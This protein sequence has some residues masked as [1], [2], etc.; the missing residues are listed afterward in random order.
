[1][2]PATTSARLHAAAVDARRRTS[3]DH[4]RGYE[5]ISSQQ[6]MGTSHWDQVIRPPPI[7]PGAKGPGPP[8]VR[9]AALEEAAAK[10]EEERRR[11]GENAMTA[12]PYA[13]MNGVRAEAGETG[14]KTPNAAVGTMADALTPGTALL[15]G[16]MNVAQSKAGS[17][18]GGAG[19]AALSGPNA[20]PVGGALNKVVLKPGPAGDKRRRSESRGAGGPR[21]G[22]KDSRNRRTRKGT[23]YN[24]LGAGC[25]V[26]FSFWAIQSCRSR[27][28]QSLLNV[29]RKILS[30]HQVVIVDRDLVSAKKRNPARAL[31][32]FRWA[33]AR[34]LT[35]L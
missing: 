15:R 28:R 4:L 33:R 26:V 24:L 29:L 21:R 2:A 22:R 20:Q 5:T 13:A 8:R 35:G 17:G 32:T 14:G 23:V 10:S 3:G 19:A 30:A 9:S 27:R 12:N 7:V 1:M 6:Q 34:R 25:C 31:T 11:I 18:V 16:A